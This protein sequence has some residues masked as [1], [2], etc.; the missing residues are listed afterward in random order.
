MVLSRL[1]DKYDTMVVLGIPS[2]PPPVIPAWRE[3]LGRRGGRVE[4]R[5]HESCFSMHADP[6]TQASSSANVGKFAEFLKDTA[7][8][9]DVY[10]KMRTR[11]HW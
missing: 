9:K 4:L 8:P 5:Y 10:R 11:G 1:D 3:I 2:S 6:R 7:A